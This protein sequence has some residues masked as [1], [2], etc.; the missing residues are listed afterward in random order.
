M[1]GQRGSGAIAPSIVALPGSGGES[2]EGLAFPPL[3]LDQ[4]GLGRPGFNQ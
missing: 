1:G 2:R 4:V 3:G